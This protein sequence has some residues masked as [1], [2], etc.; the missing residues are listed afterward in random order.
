[1]RRRAGVSRLRLRGDSVF[2][3]CDVDACVVLDGFRLT[4]TESR[5]REHRRPTD[6]VSITPITFACPAVVSRR[7]R[8]RDRRR[9]RRRSRGLG[10]GGRID[11]RPT[12]VRPR[13]ES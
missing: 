7:A 13:G 4:S 5:V 12:P 2:D 8:V 10:A 1:M 3:A 11:R 9:R 6:V